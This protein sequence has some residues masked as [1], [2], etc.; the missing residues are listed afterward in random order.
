[1]SSQ[2][3]LIQRWNKSCTVTAAVLLISLHI[4]AFVVAAYLC[5][6]LF[7]ARSYEGVHC[8]LRADEESLTLSGSGCPEDE[9]NFC[10]T[11]D[12]G[13]IVRLRDIR[14]SFKFPLEE[15]G[16]TVSSWSWRLVGSLALSLRILDKNFSL[17]SPGVGG[18]LLLSASLDYAVFNRNSFG[19]AA[20]GTF[21]L[22]DSVNR[23]PISNIVYSEACFEIQM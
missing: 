21:G 5:P 1:M 8:Q 19:A 6:D 22:T 4:T 3:T 7:I 15:D 14:L 13:D 18:E 11:R 23:L 2:G 16:E 12:T 17:S 9:E 10:R 20:N